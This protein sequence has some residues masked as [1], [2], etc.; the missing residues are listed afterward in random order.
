MYQNLSLDFLFQGY[1]LKEFVKENLPTSAVQRLQ[2]S[3]WGNRRAILQKW[4]II[5][6]RGDLTVSVARWSAMKK[7]ADKIFLSS[8]V[9]EDKAQANTV[10]NYMVTF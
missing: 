1:K 9:T 5:P 7:R 3:F 10:E 6:E 8:S 4:V 2:I